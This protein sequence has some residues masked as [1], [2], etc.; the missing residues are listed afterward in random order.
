MPKKKD[1]KEPIPDEH[2]RQIKE[3]EHHFNGLETEIRKFAS[4]W[5][6]AALGAIA[7]LIRGDITNPLVQPRVLVAIVCLM[8]NIGLVVLWVLDQLVYHRLLNAVFL[9][10]LRMEYLHSKL[11]PIRTLMVLYSKKRG[12]ARYIRFYYLAPMVVL[13]V[14]SLIASLWW[15]TSDA[16]ASASSSAVA[17]LSTAVCALIVAWTWWR[18]NH[19]ESYAEI[20]EGFGDSDFAQYLKDE[21][22]EVVLSRG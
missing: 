8:G 1:K 2:Y 21:K 17:F 4:A 11:P 14:A 20:S 5:L 18:S 22:Y 6:L 13:T 9:L 7:F 19:R 3:Y 16:E 15:S 10:G 12:M